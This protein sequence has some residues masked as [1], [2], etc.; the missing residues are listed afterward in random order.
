[1][2][3]KNQSWMIFLHD[4]QNI[5]YGAECVIGSQIGKPLSSRLSTVE[6]FPWN[7]SYFSIKI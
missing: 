6:V 2:E 7:S 3:T 4:L 5:Q 1:M